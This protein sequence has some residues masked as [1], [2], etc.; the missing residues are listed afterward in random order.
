MWRAAAAI[1]DVWTRVVPRQLECGKIRGAVWFVVPGSDVRTKK[2][3][4]MRRVVLLVI[5]VLL[6]LLMLAPVASAHDA[7]PCSGA[8]VDFAQHHIVPNATE[9]T[10][11]AGGHIPGTHMGF[12]ACV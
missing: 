8:G 7:G 6:L 4:Q 3:G 9:G 12:S 10:L 11:G 5:G 2:E 1:T